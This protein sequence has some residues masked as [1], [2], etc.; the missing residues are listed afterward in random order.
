MARKLAVSPILSPEPEIVRRPRKS[1]ALLIVLLSLTIIAI[2]NKDMFVVAIVNGRPVSRMALDRILIKQYGAQTLDNLTTEK[3]IEQELKSK[4]VK[5]SDSEVDEKIEQIKKELPPGLTFEQA[6]EQGKTTLKEL[7]TN[8]RLQLSVE[9]HL[10]SRITVSEEEINAY[11]KEN[12]KTLTA[13]E[14]GKQREEVKGI[15]N[16]QKF[17]EVFGSWLTELQDKAKVSKFIK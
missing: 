1:L 2:R 16:K 5:V 7:K 3:I 17:N 10:A 6:L 4:K 15:L 13:T 14:E 8:I 11:L 9:K 12:I